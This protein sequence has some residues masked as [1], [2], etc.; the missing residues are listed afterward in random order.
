MKSGRR[1]YSIG[2]RSVIKTERGIIN[3]KI[4]GKNSGRI[5]SKNSGKICGKIGFCAEFWQK[6]KE[7]LP[8]LTEIFVV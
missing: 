1:L 2:A 5:C 7:R 3:G 6:I 8:D 4:G